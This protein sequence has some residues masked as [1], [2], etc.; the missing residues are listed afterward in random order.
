MGQNYIGA[1][2]CTLLADALKGTFT[3]KVIDLSCNLLCRNDVP[4]NNYDD[5][6]KR[7]HDGK[8]YR[9]MY[10]D[11]TGIIALAEALPDTNICQLILKDNFEQ[12]DNKSEMKILKPG[13]R[14]TREKSSEPKSGGSRGRWTRREPNSRTS[15]PR[16][17]NNGSCRCAPFSRRT[18]RKGRPAS[19]HKM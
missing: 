12:E 4:H 10:E 8:G 6:P 2:G 9:D 19:V 17:V 5:T 11:L 3:L 13:G 18:S 7:E 16:T 14:Q 1:K 15:R